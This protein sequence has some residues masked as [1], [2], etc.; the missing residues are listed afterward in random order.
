MPNLLFWFAMLPNPFYGDKNEGGGEYRN[1]SN[2]Q[3]KMG[4]KIITQIDNVT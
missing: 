3:L 1:H 4:N 2:M